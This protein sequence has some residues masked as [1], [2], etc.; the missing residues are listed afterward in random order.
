MPDG[1]Q[2]CLL[3]ETTVIITKEVGHCREGGLCC[4][5]CMGQQRP[6]QW[7]AEFKTYTDYTLNSLFTKAINNTKIHRWALLH[8]NNDQY[9]WRRISA[10]G[11][12]ITEV[13]PDEQMPSLCDLD[14]HAIAWQ[15]AIFSS[16]AIQICS[17]SPSAPMQ[18]VAADLIG[19]YSKV[20]W[21]K[22]IYS[23]NRRSL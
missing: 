10:P 18:I 6:C 14:Y 20:L 5:E 13:P 11:G 7:G 23:H 12:L 17:S 15:L 22:P 16:P 4:S 1:W 19:L 2:R 8:S 9:I 3:M 21:W